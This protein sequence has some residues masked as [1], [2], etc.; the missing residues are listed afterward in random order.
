M[1]ILTSP[2]FLVGLVGIAIF[3][4]PVW[5]YIHKGEIWAQILKL[6]TFGGFIIAVILCV[7]TGRQEIVF[8]GP[9]IAFI[10]L[11]SII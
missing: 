2:A 4:I 10:L 11:V 3:A 5:K 8:G 7:R 9:V 6:I 1:G